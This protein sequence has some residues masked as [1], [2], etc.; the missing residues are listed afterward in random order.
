MSMLPEI[1]AALFQSAKELDHD[2]DLESWIR[3]HRLEPMVYGVEVPGLKLSDAFMAECRQSYMNMIR[4]SQLFLAES[5]RL[6]QLLSAKNIPGFTWRG[7]DYGQRYYGDMALRYFADLDVMVPPERRHDALQVMKDAGYRLRSRFIPGWF[8]SRHHHHWPM[9]SHDGRF[10]LEVHWAVDNPYR[11]VG[12]QSVISEKPDEA[13]RIILACLHAEKESRLQHC[14]SVEELSRQL[15]L[16]EPV[17]P[18]LDLAVMVSQADPNTIRQLIDETVKGPLK[19][20]V[21]RSMWILHHY[22]GVSTFSFPVQAPV[23]TRNLRNRL[24]ARLRHIP[25]AQ[26]AGRI[27]HCRPDVL[28][29]WLDYLIPEKGTLGFG[30]RI[31]FA[32]KRAVKV[33]GLFLDGVVC[34]IWVILQKVKKRFSSLLVAA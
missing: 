12:M 21:S 10:P 3:T 9:I 26:K 7:V 27:L 20:I 13:A 29:D 25:M 28:L 24:H 6:N 15:L 31:A 19:E 34:G 33:F 17:L 8:L 23:F 30:S 5:I 32:A 1:C 18:W 16:E 4:R 2:L 22:F 11:D 14:M